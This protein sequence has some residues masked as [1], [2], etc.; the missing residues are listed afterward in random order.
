MK[1]Q[2][3]TENGAFPR[4][5]PYITQGPS[6]EMQTPGLCSLAAL[7]SSQAGLRTCVFNVPQVTLMDT[8][9]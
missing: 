4:G 5:D 9:V 8:E 1:P 2:V 7:E 3:F 6:L